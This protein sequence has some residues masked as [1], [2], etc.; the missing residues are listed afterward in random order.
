MNPSFDLMDKTLRLTYAALERPAE[1]E[2]CAE[3]ELAELKG[4]G[5]Y[6][7]EHYM[8]AAEAARDRREDR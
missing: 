8:M 3:C 2:S 5:P 1:K 6:C 7:P 4:H